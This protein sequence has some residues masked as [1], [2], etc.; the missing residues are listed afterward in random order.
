MIKLKPYSAS[1]LAF[2]G[3]LL[4]AMGIYF[5]LM[6]TA[7]LPEDLRYMKTTLPVIHDAIP[8]LSAWL[9]K[10]FWV[11]GGYIF[12]T[13]LLTIFIAFTLFRNR[14]HGVF[15]MITLAGISSIGSMTVVNFVI[16]SDFKWLLLIF[17]LPWVIALIL[18]RLHK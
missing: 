9:Q 5:I 15:S 16:G 11:M 2:A 6:R 10:V 4:V 13:G 14:L 3:L 8:G 18:Y 12:T 1:M 17:T 7:L